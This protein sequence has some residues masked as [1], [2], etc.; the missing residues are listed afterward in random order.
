MPGCGGPLRKGCGRVLPEA[1]AAVATAGGTAV[2]QAMAE[3]GWQTAKAGLARVFGRG[4][5]GRGVAAEERLERSRAQLASVGE[6]ELEEARAAQAGVWQ[7][8]LADLLEEHP[9]VE[10]ELR[11]WVSDVQ[12]QSVT[13]VSTGWVEQSVVG[14]DQSRQAV[15]GHGVQNVTFGDRHG[16]G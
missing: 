6:R 3:D 13:A 1:L 5:P 12:V 16:Q 4:D 2:V 15:L 14:L 7:A 11:A 9:E 8:R 10:G